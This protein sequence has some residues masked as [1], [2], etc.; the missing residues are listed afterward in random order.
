MTRFD[1]AM[2]DGLA[3]DASRFDIGGPDLTKVRAA[4][5]R[6]RRRN[7]AL[8]SAATALAVVAAGVGI[9]TS[10]D[11]AGPTNER[12]VVGGPGTPSVMAG[13]ARD[14]MTLVPSTSTWKAD[15]VP[16]GQGL[17]ATMSHVRGDGGLVAL[18]TAPGTAAGADGVIDDQDRWMYRSDDGVHWTG[19][20]MSGAGTDGGRWLV[21]LDHRGNRIVGVGTA[22]ATAPIGAAIRAGDLVILSLA[23]ANRDPAVF[24]SPHRFDV[25]RENSKLQLAFAQGPHVCLGMHLA[26][27]E[28]QTVLERMLDRFPELRLDPEHD[29]APR[30]LVFRK[31]PLLHLLW[32]AR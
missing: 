30:G 13:A 15:V 32:S 31:P 5:R 1:D 26:R 25:L 22:L 10:V 29:P 20:A 28:T 16:Y 21:D 2:R 17:G 6:R 24:M 8:T 9:R 11:R 7:R 14:R 4:A 12:I 3:A 23:A 19:R 27:L 18:S